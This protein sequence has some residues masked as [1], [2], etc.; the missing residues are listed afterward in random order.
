MNL[1]NILASSAERVEMASTAVA[2]TVIC[3]L[4]LSFVGLFGLY[5]K[6]FRKVVDRGLEDHYILRDMVRKNRRFF[7]DAE[8]SYRDEG[9]SPSFSAHVAA[10]RTKTR[11]A[12]IVS[13]TVIIGFYLAFVALM[14][15]AVS[16][17]VQGDNF[18]VGDNSYL[19][20]RTGSMEEAH[21]SN[22]YIEENNLDDQ[23]TAYSLIQ[24][25]EVAPEDM[26][27]YKVYAFEANNTV[28]V[29][30]LISMGADEDGEMRYAFRGDANASSGSYEVSVP[31]SAVI[32]EY[33]GW[34]SFGLGLFVNYAQSEIGIITIALALILLGC[35]DVLDALIGKG[36]KDREAKIAQSV[37]IDIHDR[38]ARRIGLPYG[39]YL[40]RSVRV[41]DIIPPFHFSD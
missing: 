6:Y 41:S 27:L 13:N 7:V 9:S 38:F 5:Y 16:I 21:S 39:Q 28:V 3:L 40:D 35:Y 34:N 1:V 36:I 23:I 19:V 14:I 15:G 32:G 10:G 37:D 29:H 31:F 18:W 12:K 20:I 30:R 17:R 24:I 25:R 26:E 11:I 33:T 22:T 4:F 2:I 8:K